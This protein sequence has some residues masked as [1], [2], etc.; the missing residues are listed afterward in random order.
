[1]DTTAVHLDWTVITPTRTVWGKNSHIPSSISQRCLQHLL[2]PSQRQRKVGGRKCHIPT[3]IL[4]N[5]SLHNSLFRH[6]KSPTDEWIF[7][8][9]SSCG[10]KLKEATSNSIVHISVSSTA[11]QKVTLWIGR[12]EP[13]FTTNKG[14][15]NSVQYHHVWT[16]MF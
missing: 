4:K 13:G 5:V 10:K 15:Q 12:Q 1:M 6:F 7:D 14:Q 11:V 9:G 8:L 16:K 3:F 2:L